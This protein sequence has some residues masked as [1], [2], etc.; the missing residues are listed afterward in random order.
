[1]WVL[2]QLV[3]KRGEENE[4]EKNRRRKKQDIKGCSAIRQGST[5]DIQGS[6]VRMY[7]EEM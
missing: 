6:L 2:R 1:M 4:G 7:K 5:G 3:Y